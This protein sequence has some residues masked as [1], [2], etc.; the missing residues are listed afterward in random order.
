MNVAGKSGCRGRDQ[1]NHSKM[2]SDFCDP[3]LSWVTECDKDITLCPDFFFFFNKR[4]G[5]LNYLTK[6]NLG[7]P[8]LCLLISQILI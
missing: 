4:T 6:I 2:S 1:E 5:F 3:A 7:P 8:F